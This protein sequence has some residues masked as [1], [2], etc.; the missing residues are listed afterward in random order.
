MNLW[1]KDFR[2]ATKKDEVIIQIY[3]IAKFELTQ[4]FDQN[5]WIVKQHAK[6]IDNF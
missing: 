1:T 2:R 3:S 4:D 6:N 5:I